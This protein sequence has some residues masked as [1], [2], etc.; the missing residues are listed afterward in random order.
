MGMMIFH[1]IKSVP[2]NSCI[3]LSTRR[4]ALEYPKGDI[5]LGFCPHCGFISNVAFDPKLT[6]YSDR[7]EETQGFSTTFQKFHLELA[8]RLIERYN[9]HKKT[10]IEIG[11]GKGEF[12]SLLCELG[13]NQGIGFDPAYIDERNE[14]KAADRITF[15]KDYYS[16][17]YSF[18]QGDFLVC[19]MTLEHIPS[20][21]QFL[22]MIGQSTENK[23]NM[24]IFF[25]VPDVTKILKDTGFEDIYYEHCSYFS[26][27]S[28]SFLF[29][30]SG[31]RILHLSTIFDNQ[32]LILEAQPA[33]K[34][35]L[36]V[37]HHNDLDQLRDYIETFQI[38]FQT[39]LAF[40]QWKL[41]EIKA[42]G[43]RVV[44][45]GSGSKAVSF[46]TTLNIFDEI[47]YVVDIN[48]YRQG[49]YMAGSGQQIVPPSF[50]KDYKPDT[51]IIMN[52]IYKAE[53][54][55]EIKNMELTSEVITI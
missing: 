47:Q 3:L 24:I 23:L 45:W 36:P 1:E 54:Q 27:G 31:F 52:P 44:L 17:K 15:V 9:L 35:I 29:Q 28:L 13:G 22:T 37:S 43:K 53:I 10:I 16:E 2:A 26:P 39:K 21:K 25:Q 46:L 50:L 11:C 5:L 14:S 20:T 12:L 40:W 33:G 41:N 34:N 48:P 42:S 18:Y 4:E 7:Y 30:N 6:E 51:V 38:N 8:N 32:Y 49:F 55:G 19:K